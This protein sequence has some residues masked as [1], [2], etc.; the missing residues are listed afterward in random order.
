[1]YDCGMRWQ[2][3]E[4]G[5]GRNRHGLPVIV[6]LKAV[7]PAVGVVVEAPVAEIQG[8]L[9][10]GVQAL[11]R[12][13]TGQQRFIFPGKVA[14]GAEDAG[15]VPATN[16]LVHEPVMAFEGQLVIE[17]GVENVRPI[18]EGRPVVEMPVEAGGIVAGVVLH[19]TDSIKRLGKGVVEVE[20]QAM[21]AVISQIQ[22]QG[23]VVGSVAAGSRE[24]VE[25]LQVIEWS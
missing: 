20:Q 23:V 17:D 13:H 25:D 16:E 3:I 18:E 14:A 8:A 21:P 10:L 5:H 12:D 19:S 11:Q 1:M 4:P 6:I 22:N 24:K 15:S 9:Y 2:R 7:A